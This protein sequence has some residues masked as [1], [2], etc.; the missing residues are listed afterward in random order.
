MTLVPKKKVT[1]NPVILK[2]NEA[3]KWQCSD[4]TG[5]LLCY[6]SAHPIKN[7]TTGSRKAVAKCCWMF[8]RASLSL[9]SLCNGVT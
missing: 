7:L 1:E 9:L 6:Y 5:I 8:Q 2:E 4:S 3:L